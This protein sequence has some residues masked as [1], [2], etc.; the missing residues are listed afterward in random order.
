MSNLFDSTAF[1]NDVQKEWN[2]YQVTEQQRAAAWNSFHVK[3]LNLVSSHNWI[4]PIREFWNKTHCCEQSRHYPK[5]SIEI[6]SR[7]FKNWSF[8]EWNDCLEQTI[9]NLRSCNIEILFIMR[10]SKVLCDR[11]TTTRSINLAFL[12]ILFLFIRRV[13]LHFLLIVTE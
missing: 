4:S 10:R 6:N 1:E 7:T 13:R 9:K 5:G 11:W 8:R 12:I 2:S 3:L